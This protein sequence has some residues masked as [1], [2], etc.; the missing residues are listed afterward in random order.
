[1][2]THVLPQW[3]SW[4]LAKIEQM[5]VEEWVKDLAAR[6]SHWVVAKALQLTS[7]V[8]RSAVRNRLI[9]VN[10]CEEVK[11]PEGRKRD[12]DGGI[13]SQR[14]LRHQLVPAVP[15][16]YRALVAIA[17]GTGLRWGEVVG[18]CTDS[19]NLDA[20]TV[21]VVRTIVEVAGYTSFKPYPK[22]RAGRRHVPLPS[23]CITALR[24]HLETHPPEDN[25][26][27]FTNEA[28]GALR[29]TLF[30]TR[31]WRP[32]LVRA[33]LL[34]EIRVDGDQFEA[35]WTDDRNNKHSEQFDSE[36]QAVRHVAR[37]QAGGLRFHGLRH[38]YG[39]WLADDGVPPNKVQ[40]VMGHENVT[41]TLQLYVRKTEDH[42]AIL[43]VLD[44]EKKQDT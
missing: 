41:T 16:R 1:M 17:G 4:Q 3:G 21:H 33:G 9:G 2:R 6:R 5:H 18:L 42:D 11:I 15:H 7:N 27:I 36:G 39:T 26:L 10:P 44:D 14:L 12:T 32:S 24:E 25:G 43:D 38:S 19:V 13:I 28:G 23:W 35:I 22:S 8:M 40:K 34:G 20:G 37:Y 31:V 29:R 30:R